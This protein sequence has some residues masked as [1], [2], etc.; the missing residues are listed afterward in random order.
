MN[1]TSNSPKLFIHKKEEYSNNKNLKTNQHQQQHQHKH[2]NPND[3]N[4][5]SDSQSELG[6][7]FQIQKQTQYIDNNSSVNSLNNSNEINIYC[8]NCG[9]KGH[10]IKKCLQPI[11][12]LG[13]ICIRLKIPL[14]MNDIINYS[15]KIQN[16]Y[17]FTLDEINKL[18]KIKNTMTNFNIDELD[19]NIEYLFIRRKN[20]LNYVEF[21]RGKYFVRR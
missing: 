7:S 3:S 13:I 12:S 18:K 10:V 20:S 11:I 6:D 8:L 2:P 17:L 16:N 5:E 14:N 15:K 4:I 1:F 9:K 21:L 19:S